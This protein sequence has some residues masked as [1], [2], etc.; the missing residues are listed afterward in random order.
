MKQVSMVYESLKGF[1]EIVFHKIDGLSGQVFEK[2]LFVISNNGDGSPG[3]HARD[4]QN[5][6]CVNRDKFCTQ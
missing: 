5:K 6:E 4:D 3:H 2:D 1:F